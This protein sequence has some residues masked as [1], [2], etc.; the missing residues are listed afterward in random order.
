VVRLGAF[1]PDTNALHRQL[2]D[3]GQ[4]LLIR[5]QSSFTMFWQWQLSRADMAAARS[6]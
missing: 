6:S 4:H 2:R 5:D 1:W 3:D